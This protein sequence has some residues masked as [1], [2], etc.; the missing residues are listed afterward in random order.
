VEVRD[1]NGHPIEGA[2]VT[3]AVQSGEGQVSHGSVQTGPDGRASSAW[4]LGCSNQSPQSLQAHVAAVN[5]TFTATA[6]LTQLVICDQILPRGRSTLAYSVQLVAV[7]GGLG[8]L[9]WGL[10]PGG[11]NPPPGLIL[12][13]DGSLSGI[14]AQDGTFSF[15]AQVDNGLGASDTAPFSLKVCQAP[16]SLPL[17]G[18]QAFSV[19]ALD[20][21]GLFLPAGVNG[22]RYRIGLV[23][24]SSA[25]DSSDVA[26]VTV[27]MKKNVGLGA[28]S[29]RVQRIS[30]PSSP[31]RMPG[32]P[33]GSTPGSP[34]GSTLS[35]AG[36]VSIQK[37]LDAAAATEAFHRRLRIA[38]RELFRRMGPELRP[39]PDRRGLRRGPLE[40]GV[41]PPS[42]APAPEKQSFRHPEGD[43]TSCELGE[44]VTGVKI[45]ENDAMVFY[46]D[47]T[48]NANSPV[49]LANVQSLL[50]YYRDYG[51]PVIDGYAGGVADINGD[52]RIVVLVTPE[53]GGNVVAF[54]WSGD[55]FPRTTGCPASNEMEFVR[56]NRTHIQNLSGGNPSYQALGA[57]VHEIKHVSSLYNSVARNSYQPDFV[58]EGTAEIV[59]ELSSRLAW[60]ATGGPEV[61][62]TVDFDDWT[63]SSPENWG[64][65][66]KLV[67]TV[68]YLG[69]QP[70]GVLET[71]LGA[72]TYH[73]AYGSGWHFHRWLGNAYGNPSTPLAEGSLFTTLNDSLSLISVA[74][75]E[76]AT[77]R[78]WTQ[79]MEE[80]VAAIMLNGTNAPQGPRSITS[81][82]FPGAIGGMNSHV[83]YGAERPDLYPWPVNVA[84]GSHTSSFA[85]ATNTGL[86]GPSGIRILDLTSNGTGLG[87]EMAVT[88]SKQL[89]R[90]VVVRIH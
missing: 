63:D 68:V 73:S 86:L 75:I 22:D 7:W 5:A 79:L 55:F 33:P 76:A 8:N 83:T 51:K 21:C 23:Y 17:G 31:F 89:V 13:P 2:T 87:L 12:N 57:L 28:L 43:Y 42:P 88:S 69:S 90:V 16:L 25:S 74:G 56:F 80:Y 30:T 40:P 54:V 38:E 15:L 58:E 1:V 72:G 24:A 82:D 52:G 50:D 61:G 60:A 10:Q 41:S 66:L 64:V 3:F 4:Q 77:G 45:A 32:S 71:P 34:L 62:A 48:Q 47:S 81:Y 44:T 6:D 18:S 35:A 84:G 20:D 70:N 27:S 53:A 29:P 11:G 37:G 46:Q 59:G 39:L 19:P 85:T 67:R 78:Q 26:S 65:I 36:L 9:T 14:P 49:S